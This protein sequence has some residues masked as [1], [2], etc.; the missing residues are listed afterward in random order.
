VSQCHICQ[1]SIKLSRYSRFLRLLGKL[2]FQ[3]VNE[4]FNSSSN[5][6]LHSS[7]IKKLGPSTAGLQKSNL[8]RPQHCP[9][10][11]D[12][13]SKNLDFSSSKVGSSKI[14]SEHYFTQTT[15]CCLKAFYRR[16][17][18]PFSLLT[19][20]KSFLGFFYYFLFG[21]LV[22]LIFMRI[23]KFFEKQKVRKMT[24]K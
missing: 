15:S 10:S 21:F 18:L 20:K 16:D 11:M 13:Y 19:Q 3:S 8:F 17:I 6:I 2:F 1:V 9:K 22:L 12:H 5:K 4:I 14:S 7:G 24:T 23:L